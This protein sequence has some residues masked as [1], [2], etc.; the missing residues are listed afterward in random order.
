MDGQQHSPATPA[1]SSGLATRLRLRDASGPAYAA[2]FMLAIGVFLFSDCVLRGGMLFQRDLSLFF[3]GW[4]DAFARC[5]AE[6]SWPVWNP[7]PSY[8]QPFL[9]TATAQILYPTTWLNLIVATSTYLTFFAVLHVVIGGLGAWAFV[10][11]LGASPAAGLVA[12]AAWAASGP[13]LSTVNMTNMYAAAAWLPWAA[14]FGHGTLAGRSRTS[15]VFWGGALA[16]TVLAG[17]PETML[18]SLVAVLPL[19]AEHGVR[20]QV[21]RRP[22]RTL[23]CVALAGA[24]AAALSAAEWLPLLEWFRYSDRGAMVSFGKWSN[25]PFILAQ[26]ALPLSLDPLPM[27][28][29]SRQLLFSGREPFLSSIYMGGPL[30][31]VAL[32]GI[33]AGGRARLGWPLLGVFGVVLSFGPLTPLYDVLRTVLPFLRSFR[34][35]AKSVLLVAFAVAVLAGLGVDALRAPRRRRRLLWALGVIVPAGLL[36]GAAFHLAQPTAPL[37]HEIVGPPLGGGGYDRYPAF[38]RMSGHLLQAGA[39]LSLTCILVAVRALRPGPA[40]TLAVLLGVLGVGDLLL[41]T[42]ELNPTVPGALE[43]YRP[44]LLDPIPRLR[45]NRTLVI[46]Y[47]DSRVASMLLSRG[48]GVQVPYGSPPVAEYAAFHEHPRVLG[49]GAW[50]IEGFPEDVPSLASRPATDATTALQ[51][52]AITADYP[53]LL[54]A[55][56]VQYVVSLHPLAGALTQVSTDELPVLDRRASLWAVRDP[57]PRAY[58]V[59]R[60]VIDDDDIAVVRRVYEDPSFDPRDE[61]ILTRDDATAAPVE[62]RAGAT[63][64]ARIVLLKPDLAEVETEADRDGYLVVVEGFAPG[65]RGTVDGRPAR[66]LRANGYFRAVRVPAGRHRVTMRYRPLVIPIGVALSLAGLLVAGALLGPR[67]GRQGTPAPRP[68]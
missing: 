65:W 59:G 34:F 2:L 12:G 67:G 62:G 31:V 50:G 58:W 60:S 10:R 7:Y 30:L 21:R 61:V 35:P 16:L 5:V 11:G 8:G 37:W 39:A 49:T 54:R 25:H 4:M 57:L 27:T 41:H 17:S 36:A 9:S 6:G 15:A 28:H 43:R 46:N 3:R 53:R 18:M 56:G 47:E 48:G 55:M 24:L 26:A 68:S 64:S 23:G 52:G 66:V 29:E 13:V 1:G 40:P 33:L 20:E 19:L 51:T 42:R 14:H 22:G 45:P 44:K 38:V 63:G 32:A